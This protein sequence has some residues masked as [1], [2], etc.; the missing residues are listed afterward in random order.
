MSTTPFSESDPLRILSNDQFLDI[1]KARAKPR[2]Q[3]Y[4]LFWVALRPTYLQRDD[5]V[6]YKADCYTAPYQ[7]ER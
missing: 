2:F 1:K 4:N 5:N 7:S 3:N 6:S